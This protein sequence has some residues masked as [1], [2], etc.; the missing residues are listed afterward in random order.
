[1]AP[2]VFVCHSQINETANYY[3]KKKENI[4][5]SISDKNYLPAIEQ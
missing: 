1:M 5:V 4:T 2:G 3:F